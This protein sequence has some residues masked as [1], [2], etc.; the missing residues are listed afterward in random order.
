MFKAAS[1]KNNSLL[2]VGLD[3]EPS[4]VPPEC[5]VSF[6]KMLIAATYGLA[7]AYK[8]NLALYEAMG[9]LGI[10]ALNQTLEAIRKA[11]SD[12]P[13]IGDAKRGD[14]GNCGPAYVKTAFEKFQ[15]DAVTVNPYMGSDSIAPFLEW[16]DK[17]VIVLCRTSNPGGKDLQDLLVVDG[18]SPSP[19]PL[20]QVVASLA[21]EWN[22]NNNV[23]LVLGATF[24]D[25]IGKVR[26][27]CPD[28]PFLIPGVG[29]Q[30]GDLRATVFNAVDS[31]GSG[32]MINVSRKIMYEARTTEGTL[33]LDNEALESVRKVAR[34]LRDEINHYRDA[35]VHRVL[36]A[37]GKGWP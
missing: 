27:I 13:I 7:C 22:E 15:F 14:I 10:D 33:K 12:V 17:G 1:E 20:Y 11:D 3:P 4:L 9:H 16:K 19:R 31:D 23:G 36:E 37:E 26:D 21:R 5:V 6:N 18:R 24:P 8:P 29:A 34:E 30:G 32:F 28:M 25:E 35:A 2:C